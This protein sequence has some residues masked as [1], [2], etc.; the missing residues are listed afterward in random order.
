MAEGIETSEELVALQELGIA[1]GQGY[2]FARP[3]LTPPRTLDAKQNA[4]F[5]QQS[6]H[7]EHGRSGPT[8]ATLLRWVQPLSSSAVIEEAFK[9]FDG[10]PDLQ[11][12]PV[13]EEGKPVGI[14][15]RY[16]LIDR[17]AKPFQREV[18]GRRS[19]DRV[20]NPSPLIVEIDTPLQEVGRRIADAEENHLGTGFII[21]EH[22]AYRG[23][24]TGQDLMRVLTRMQLEAARHAN[25][26]TGLPGN[27]PLNRTIDEW[28]AAGHSF[29]AA[30]VDLDHFKPYNDTYGYAMG[31][32][33]IRS[34][35]ALLLAKTDIEGDFIAHI[36]G[37]DFLMLLR[38]GNWEE[39]CQT[40]LNEFEKAVQDCFVQEHRDA[41]GYMAEDRKG[42]TAFIPLVSVSIGVVS[43]T[44]SE[45]TT[46]HQVSA[47][48]AAA[49]KQAKKIKGNSLF[50]D[51]RLSAEGKS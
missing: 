35:G 6:H 48:A 4:H 28:L 27:Q 41:G 31:D 9:V 11:S 47:A 23:I 50:V 16:E 33:I 44:P 12:L 7:D 24:G 51:R 5:K 14:I 46:H 40:I 19:C 3:T 15:A 22:G 49:K 20:M 39:E 8:V 42:N 21:V 26:L 25:A 45:Y 34:L 18:F 43:I 30:Y 38:S 2:Y 1:F 36:G 10:Q 17:L 32:R 37:D 13:I 29:K